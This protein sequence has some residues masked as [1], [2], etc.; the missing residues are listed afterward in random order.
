MLCYYLHS[1]G[2]PFLQNNSTYRD[3][4]VPSFRTIFSDKIKNEKF[5][6]KFYKY[7]TLKIFSDEIKISALSIMSIVNYILWKSE[8]LLSMRRLALY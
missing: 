2:L 3:D 5:T 4:K 1:I 7:I 6:G 8:I